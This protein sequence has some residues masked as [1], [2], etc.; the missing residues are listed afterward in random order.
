MPQEWLLDDWGLSLF[1]PQ[2][3]SVPELILGVKHG[4]SEASEVAALLVTSGCQ[5]SI[6]RSHAHVSDATT[7]GAHAPYQ[8][9]P[10]CYYCS[11]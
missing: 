4:S 2:S 6:G 8:S 5:R 1:W 11:G 3:A 7:S 9:M 10:P